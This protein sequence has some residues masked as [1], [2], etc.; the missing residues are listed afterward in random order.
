MTPYHVKVAAEAFA[1]AKDDSDFAKKGP[2]INFQNQHLCL[3][4]FTEIVYINIRGD[5]YGKNRDDAGKI[6]Y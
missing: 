3:D 4:T 2:M 1:A 5:K 6:E